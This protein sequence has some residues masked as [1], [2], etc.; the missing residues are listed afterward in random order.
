MTSLQAL[1][2]AV[3]AARSQVDRQVGEARAVAAAGKAAEARVAQL[4]ELVALHDRVSVLLTR[5]G[6]EEQD[7]AQ[8]QVEELVTR[9]LQTIFDERLS[10]HIVQEVKS[11]QAHVSFVIRSYIGETTVDTPV[12][13]ARGGGM[14]A[15]VGFLLRLVVLLLTAGARR[16]LFLDEPFAHVSAEFRQRVGQFLREVSTQAGVQIVMVTHDPEYEELADVS[17]RVTQTPDGVTQVTQL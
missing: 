12:M 1:S 16:V 10:F 9:G 7:T 17:V 14:A 13:D 6:E 2:A 8:R 4:Q 5:L 15:V 3:Q 11:N